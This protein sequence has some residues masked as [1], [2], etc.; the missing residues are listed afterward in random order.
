MALGR[1]GQS[2][3]RR[4]I[5]RRQPLTTASATGRIPTLDR[6]EAGT[7]LFWPCS[8][9]PLSCLGHGM[10]SR[11]SRHALHY[12]KVTGAANEAHADCLRI[13]TRAEIMIAREIDAAQERDEIGKNGVNQYRNESV[14]TSDTLGLDR[15]RVAEWRDLAEAGVIEECARQFCRLRRFARPQLL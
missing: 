9:R 2:Q 6:R 1:I 4:L 14:Q 12:A 11:Q 13:I 3:R 5:P 15:R 10:G 8:E 7:P